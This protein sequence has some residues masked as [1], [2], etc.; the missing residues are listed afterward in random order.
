MKT[1]IIEKVEQQTENKCLETSNKIMRTKNE[2]ENEN[3]FQQINIHNNL[4]D[5]NRLKVDV[6]STMGT[7]NQTKFQE[8]VKQIKMTSMDKRRTIQ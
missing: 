8:Y 7:N 2:N 6:L 5:N 3:Q 4:I 1:N